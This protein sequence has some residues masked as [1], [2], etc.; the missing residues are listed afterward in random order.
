MTPPLLVVVVR[1][2]PPSSLSSTRTT[3]GITTT[4]VTCRHSRASPSHYLRTQGAD[5]GAGAREV[6][7]RKQ[8]LKV[9]IR[10]ARKQAPKTGRRRP[11]SRFDGDAGCGGSRR[12]WVKPDI[13]ER[14][15]RQLRNRQQQDPSWLLPPSPANALPP[16][17]SNT[18]ARCRNLPVLSLSLSLFPILCEPTKTTQQPSN[19]KVSQDS[20]E[21][22][23]GREWG[24]GNER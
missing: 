13:K 23:K 21:S 12:F 1:A 10:R 14:N 7:P 9:E 19:N 15:K 16:S 6:E 22:D 20:C 5:R 8:K 3:T 17:P 24:W 4:P 18:P 2:P 11:F